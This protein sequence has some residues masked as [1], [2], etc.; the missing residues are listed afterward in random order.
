MG[1]ERF[2]SASTHGRRAGQ[3]PEHESCRAGIFDST[4]RK[5]VRSAGL[6][7][8]AERWPS[9][10]RQRFAKPSYGVNLY[11]G[12]ES[13]P[14]RQFSE[15]RPAAIRMKTSSGLHALKRARP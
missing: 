8:R 10:L 3:D 15:L 2:F 14:L 6:V 7:W 13:L 11:R 9:G 1:A 4:R 12:F 5:P